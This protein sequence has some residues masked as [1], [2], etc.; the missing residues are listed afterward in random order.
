MT[1]TLLLILAGAAMLFGTVLYR[2]P[3]TPSTAEANEVVFI[4]IDKTESIQILKSNGTTAFGSI[5]PGTVLGKI[6]ATGKYRPVGKQV[7]GATGSLQTV[8]MASVKGFFVGD[9]ITGYDVSGSTTLFTGRTITAI[10]TSTPS[11]TVSGG[12]ITYD[13]GDYIY[14]E[15]GSATARGYLQSGVNTIEGV[16]ADGTIDSADQGGALVYEGVVDEDKADAVIKHNTYIKT[17][18]QTPSNGCMILFR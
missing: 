9:T 16:L 15:D 4:A 5:L 6:T 18:L 17:D 7:V 1:I 10:N 8:T 2:Q 11:I 13:T 3:V 12:A 14:V